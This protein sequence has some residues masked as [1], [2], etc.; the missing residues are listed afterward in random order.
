M[1]QT[2]ALVKPETVADCAE[3][4]GDRARRASASDVGHERLADILR[5][6]VRCG[7][8]ETSWVDGPLRPL[9]PMN[10]IEAQQDDILRAEAQTRQAARG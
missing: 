7:R 8:G 10:I 5:E 9:G 3:R 4:R 1:A 2:A 6:G